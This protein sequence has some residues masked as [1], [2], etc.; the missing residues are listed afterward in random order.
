MTTAAPA[1]PAAPHRGIKA[2]LARHPLLSYSLIAYAG[3][4]L[5]WL[6]LLLSKGGLGLMSFSS[7]IGV[8]VT[9][10][11]GSFSGPALAAFIMTGVTEGREGIHRLLRSMVLWRVELRWYP[12]I[13]L[14]IPLALTL[15]AI[16]VPGNLASFEPMD[17]LSVLAS[18]LLLYIYP[19]LIIGGPLGE[20]PGWR[21]FAL[22]RLQRKYGPMVGSLILAPLWAFWHVPIWLTLWRAAGM[23]NIYNLLM[24]LLFITFW[25]IV[26]T[27][28]FNNTHG[29]VLI[30]ILLHTSVDAFPNG[31]LWPLLPTSNTVTSYGVLVGYFGM[32]IG[33][34]V[35]A[36]AV[37]ALTRGR[38]SYQH[39]PQEDAEPDLATAPT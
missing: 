38:L 39:H 21:G 36:L 23:L 18:Y 10:G 29:S 30:A 20:E 25:T 34:G 22:P 14:G 27:W 24:Y 3:T 12:F 17:P 37:I 1:Q 35:S 9:G 8:L 32:V 28:V 33:M 15:G 31:I 11:I 16:V 5:V 4:W 2:L 13:L 7:P 26:M 19:A 6:P